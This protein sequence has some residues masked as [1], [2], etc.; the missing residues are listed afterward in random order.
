MLFQLH[1][2]VLAIALCALFGCDVAAPSIAD[3]SREDADDLEQVVDLDGVPVD[4]LGSTDAAVTVLVFAR[5]DCPISNRYAPVINALVE[6]FADR[7]VAF[8]MVYPG[9]SVTAEA[10]R[11]HR[12]E[13]GHRCAVARDPGLSLVRR[14]GVSVTP[15]AAVYGGGVMT[16]RGRID[17]RYVTLGRERPAPT[18]HDLRDAID[19]S[20]TNPDIEPRTTSAIGCY[21]A[22]LK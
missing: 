6:R 8:W 10:V 12:A 2:P 16:Y 15:E 3:A 20:L 17:D 18:T 11:R 22:D 13:F 1:C 19:A 4:P 21:I 5:V 7:R 14:V 9:D